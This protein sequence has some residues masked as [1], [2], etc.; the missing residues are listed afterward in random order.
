MDASLR[1]GIESI[2]DHLHFVPLIAQWHWQEWGH[3]DADGSL[4]SWTEGLMERTNR[5]DVPTTLVALSDDELIGSVTLV[6]HDMDTRLDLSPW[7]AGL[8]VHPDFRAK[9][10]GGA[11]TIAA[12]EKAASLG[13]TTLYLYTRPARDLYRRLGW[14]DVCAERY[15]G[16]DVTI[17]QIDP[18]S[19]SGR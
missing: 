15:E 3:L 17:M 11:L 12:T 19:V 1:F 10:V 18:R 2:A 16:R 13:V 6:E 5:D 4:E 7:L 8:F 14:S 9:G